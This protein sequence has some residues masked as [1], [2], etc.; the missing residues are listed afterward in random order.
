MNLSRD[1]PESHDLVGS[2]LFVAGDE[3]IHEGLRVKEF[4]IPAILIRKLRVSEEA[5][6]GDRIADEAAST[7]RAYY[8]DAAERNTRFQQTATSSVETGSLETKGA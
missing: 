1:L 6:R 3:G 2:G 5:A 8:H 7:C 4:L